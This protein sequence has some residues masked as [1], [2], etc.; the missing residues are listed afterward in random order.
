MTTCGN[1]SYKFRL[2][3]L[4]QMGFDKADTQVKYEVVSYVTSFDRG[5]FDYY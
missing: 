1:F 2:R 5:R 3:E 4:K